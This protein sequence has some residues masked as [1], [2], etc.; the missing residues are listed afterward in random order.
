MFRSVVS[1]MRA[2]R[3]L[4]MVS[5]NMRSSMLV[6]SS[7]FRFYSSSSLTKDQIQK[8]VIDVIKAFDKTKASSITEQTTFH[9][10]LGLDS[11]DTVELLVA[12]EEEFDVEFP[13]KV[14]DELK[15]VQETVDY[16]LTNPDAN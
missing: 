5:R 1:S 14:A 11:L 12:I 7:A 10:D 6:P 3:P 4:M 15:S 16:I 13:D 8:R 2:Q 9:K